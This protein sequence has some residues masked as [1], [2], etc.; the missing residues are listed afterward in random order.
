MTPRRLM[1][2]ALLAVLAEPAG[3]A[4]TVRATLVAHAVLPAAT[5]TVAPTDAPAG[6]HVP[7]RW[8][9][10]SLRR[11]ERIGALA[12]TARFYPLD[13]PGHAIAEV[14]MVDATRALVIERSGNEGD[15]RLACTAG[16]DRGCFAEP[17]G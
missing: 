1:V 4:D 3:A 14:N 11:L 5:F 15:P 13:Q 8:I 12:P 9:D 7:G 6:L 2:G 10:P 16:R 17:A